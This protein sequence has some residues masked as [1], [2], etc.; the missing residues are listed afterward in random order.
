MALVVILMMLGCLYFWY[1]GAISKAG[2]TSTYSLY[3]EEN[4]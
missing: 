3:T 4:I 2:D 1:V